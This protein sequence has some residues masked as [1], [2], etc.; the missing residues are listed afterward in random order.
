MKTTLKNMKNKGWNDN[1]L[2]HLEEVLKKDT[3]RDYLMKKNL[4]NFYYW[5]NTLIIIILNFM[6]ILLLSPFLIFMSELWVLLFT[7][8]FGVSLG[9][10]LS[11]LALSMNH[12]DIKHHIVSIVIIPLIVLADFF[13]VRE[14]TNF[15]ITQFKINTD[16]NAMLLVSIFVVTMLLPYIFTLREAFN[17]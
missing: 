12:L 11:Y 13:I 2:R 4:H 15:L 5:M 9:S 1:D 6:G 17:K 8:L 16:I 3:R 7:A 14:F 10:M